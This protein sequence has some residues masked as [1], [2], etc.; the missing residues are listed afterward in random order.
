[1]GSRIQEDA[2]LILT[3]I[4]TAGSA[5]SFRNNGCCGHVQFPL[6][7]SSA[8]SSHSSFVTRFSVVPSPIIHTP[9]LEH[10]RSILR[11]SSIVQ[12]RFYSVI[13][14]QSLTEQFCKQFMPTFEKGVKDFNRATFQLFSSNKNDF[15]QKL[16]ERSKKL[17]SRSRFD[18]A[19]TLFE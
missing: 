6:K 18:I 8:S 4:L 12:R 7:T 16:L 2:R 3:A 10:I 5:I 19:M 13:K 9:F 14:Q 11:A 17:F 15:K 1:M